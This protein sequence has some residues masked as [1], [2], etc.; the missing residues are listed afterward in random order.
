MN[1]ALLVPRLAMKDLT[2]RRTG[3]TVQPVR[4][5]V[6]T[7]FEKAATS[8]VV[9]RLVLYLTIL[10]ASVKLEPDRAAAS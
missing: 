8:S 4:T 10:A 3:C 1:M 5:A 6:D 7:M 2:A 9:Q